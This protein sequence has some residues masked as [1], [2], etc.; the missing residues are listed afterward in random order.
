MGLL[1]RCIRGRWASSVGTNQ[2]TSGPA[3]RETKQVMTCPNTSP[4]IT[5]SHHDSRRAEDWLRTE[6]SSSPMFPTIEPSSPITDAMLASIDQLTT[7]CRACL[8]EPGDGRVIHYRNWVTRAVAALRSWFD[9]PDVDRLVR[10]PGFWHLVTLYANDPHTQSLAAL[11]IDEATRRL[12]DLAGQMRSFHFRW[13][14]REIFIADT[15][16]YLHHPKTFDHIDWHDELGL[17]PLDQLRLVVPMIVIDELDKLKD[18]GAQDVR[19][20]ARETLR[21]IEELFRT[22]TEGAKPLAKD[23]PVTIELL[24]DRLE[25]ERLAGAD[26]ELV[27]RARRLQLMAGTTVTLVS[28]DT[29]LLLRA[30]AAGLTAIRS[31]AS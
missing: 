8:A 19:G 15:N 22:T 18:R 3:G 14:Y 26:N 28:R 16:L 10:T 23:S 1:S 29:G 9:F 31:A 5:R 21:R 2:A 11:E 12:S 27:D 25:H 4:R 24:M 13:R 30:R 7:E 17:L 6:L 20:R